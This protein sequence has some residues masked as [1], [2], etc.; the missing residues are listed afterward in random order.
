M[1]GYIGGAGWERLRLDE[2]EVEG[3]PG[4]MHG[5][6]AVF[7][8]DFH[9]RAN[10][11]VRAVI[12]CIEDCGA[13]IILFGGDFADEQ[14]QALRLFE[15]FR[16]LCAPMGIF[17]VPGNNDV[18]AFGS[19]PALRAALEGCGVRL[20]VNEA[21]QLDGFAVGGVDEYK[22]GQ[23]RVEGLFDGCEGWR[24]LLSHY[25]VQVGER[26]DL[27]L[28]GHTHGGQF[29]AFGLTPYAIGFEGIGRKRH[30]APAAVSGYCDL[31]SARLL[32]S[33]G[34]GTSRLPVRIGV[35]P[36]VHLLKFV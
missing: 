7:A 14:D 17:A 28:S 36:E 2:R 32:V 1:D 35:R 30:L 8:S 5:L 18:E 26:V 31:G 13:D 12:E 10:V 3:A 19:V 9:L 25:P 20:L 15:A 6:R 23:P 22:Y 27:M 11:S 34:L 29:N 21:V 16:R 4:A 33:K 24:V